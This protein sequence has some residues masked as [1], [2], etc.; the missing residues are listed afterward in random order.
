[1][2]VVGLGPGDAALVNAGTRDAIASIDRRFLRT[3]RH[4][5]AVV[6]GKAESFDEVYE[7]SADL[8]EVYR[9][10]VER[11]VEAATGHGTVLYAVPGSPV[12]AERTV[13]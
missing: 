1:M 4:P 7:Y 10:I 6:V 5:S 3:A 9:N 8:D 13:E 12:V 2:V 11:L